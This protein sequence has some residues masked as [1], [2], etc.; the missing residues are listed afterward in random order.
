MTELTERQKEIIEKGIKIIAEEGIQNLTIKNLSKV[1]GVTEG[2]LYKHYDNKHAILLG[3][4]DFFEEFSKQYTLGKGLTGI[5]SFVMERYKKF[6]D[7]PE[8]VKVMF[9]EALFINND[10]LSERMKDIMHSHKKYVDIMIEEGKKAG[11]INLVIES[12]SIFR[13][14]FGS[15]RLLVTQWCYSGYSFNLEEEGK[16]LWENIE[17]TLKPR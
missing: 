1:V 10:E 3:I 16:I 8:L 6:S 14:I 9:A 15:M 12:N 7:N 11:D 4:V 5:K 2:A 17:L 13:I